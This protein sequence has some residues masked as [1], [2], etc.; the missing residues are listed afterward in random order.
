MS[1]PKIRFNHTTHVVGKHQ[2]DASSV[3]I[4]VDLFNMFETIKKNNKQLVDEPSKESAYKAAS[5]LGK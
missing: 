5:K 4:F 1:K 2:N 3:K